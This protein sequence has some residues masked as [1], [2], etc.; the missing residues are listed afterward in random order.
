MHPLDPGEHWLAAGI[1]GLPRQREWDTVATVD[2]PGGEGD[3][4]AF[5]ALADG[6]ILVEDAPDGFDPTAFA[7]SLE[8][9]IEPP[10]RALARRRPDVWAVGASSIEVVRLQPEP[11]GDDLELTFDGETVSLRVDAMPVG[12]AGAE[13]FRTLAESREDGAYAAHAHRLDGDL[14]EILIL[15]L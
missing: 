3:E 2:A 11:R 14:W 15:P 8:G 1:T 5:V 9:A 6:R 13:A 12:A 10:Y 4:A 7:A